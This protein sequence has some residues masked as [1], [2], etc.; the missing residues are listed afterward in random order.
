V[1]N[2]KYLNFDVRI[3]ALRNN[4]RAWIS[5]DAVAGE[6]AVEFQLPGEVLQN[7]SPS[8][9]SAART[10]G[11]QLFE[12]VFASDTL[13]SLRRS[14]EIARE[15]GAGLRLRLSLSGAPELARIPWEV[16]YDPAFDHFFSL[17][18][19][20]P[21]V[22]YL[23][24]PRA[25][26][27]LEAA[28]PLKVLVML[29]SPK[30]H[31]RLDVEAEWERLCQ[32]LDELIQRAQVELHRMEEATLV[33]LQRS[34]RRD[35][36]HVFHFIGHGA[37]DERTQEGLLL[38]EG[39]GGIGK[40]VSGDFLGT[41]LHDHQ[42]LQLIL[43]NACQG[44]MVGRENPFAGA[45]GT[46]VRRGIPA[47]LAMQKAIT[48]RAALLFSQEFYSAIADGYPVD[49]ALVEGRKS[50]YMAGNPVE[51]AIPVL[52]MRSPDGLLFNLKP[53]APLPGM[54]N[55]QMAKAESASLITTVTEDRP[56]EPFGSQHIHVFRRELREIR[57]HLEKG[58]LALFVG[59]DLSRGYT[60]LPDR[61]EL[62]DE[63]AAREGLGAG[64]SLSSIAQQVM[65][66]GNRWTFTDFLQSALDTIGQEPQA[67]HRAVAA[68]VKDY[69]L[70]MVIT[71]A[72]DDLL[73]Q[74]FREIGVGLNVI[75]ADEQLAFL[76]SDRP[77]LIKLYGDLHQATS[78]TVTEQ[79]QNAL[80]R[81]R[82]KGDIV[83]EVR[84]TFRRNTILFLGYDL[85]APSVSA[86]FDE[87]AGD[88]FQRT[89]YAVWSGLTTRQAEAY[90][91]NRGLV[92]L[93]ADPLTVLQTLTREARRE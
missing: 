62:A 22:R 49:A 26:Q 9:L 14:Q 86:W 51:W 37:F 33:N 23:D 1:S 45:A 80:L 67:F 31:A 10:L 58:R 65:S 3:D 91:S 59:A 90:S 47:V 24:L 12:L 42:S 48:D 15:K 54:P 28:L 40:S 2:H 87:I 72:Y 17:S 83:D 81:G 4:Y 85:D 69:G 30:D 73:E 84:R 50:I 29:S 7:R 55:V 41:L 77:T 88:R 93:D 64:E 19:D 71:M 92:V 25:P 43:L 52:Y 39:E 46:L 6:V 13:A 53:D 20:T 36:F 70:E 34:L 63:L 75:V 79:D 16:I 57:E 61:Q 32:A 89:S 27:S 21:V 11:R 35:A 18:N 82:V 5:G 66:H 8:T 76:R 38:L 68:L 60:G 56:K 78:L 74:A 44:G